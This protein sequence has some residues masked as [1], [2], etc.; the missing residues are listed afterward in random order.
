V[1]MLLSKGNVKAIVV[2]RDGMNGDVEVVSNAYAC[3]AYMNTCVESHKK[4]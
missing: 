4:L 2:G 3:G 1:E